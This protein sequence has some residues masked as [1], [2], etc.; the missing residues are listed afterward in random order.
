MPPRRRTTASSNGSAHGSQTTLTQTESPRK[1]K[2]RKSADE[3]I[4]IYQAK[5]AA[6]QERK[7]FEELTGLVQS[8]GDKRIL[9]AVKAL[10]T[11]RPWLTGETYAR[12]RAEIEAA[13][14]E[15]RAPNAD[16]DEADEA[17]EVRAP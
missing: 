17:E 16:I 11:L 3:E 4:Q 2:V 14:R 10:R 6:A 15:N 5:L 7:F 12:V 1:A 13:I 8:L 9:G